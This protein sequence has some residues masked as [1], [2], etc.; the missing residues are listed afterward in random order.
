MP[1]SVFIMPNELTMK[2]SNVAISR[3]DTMRLIHSSMAKIFFALLLLVLPLYG[4]AQSIS[5]QAPTRVGKNQEFS[6]TYT[7]TNS[8]VESFSAPHIPVGLSVVGG[9]SRQEESSTSIINGNV[10]S[11]RSVSYTIY[12]VATSAGT[13][14]I[15][16]ANFTIGGRLVQSRSINLKVDNSSANQSP[17]QSPHSMQQG[18]FPPSGM[19][20]SPSFSTEVSERDLYFTVSP[21]QT[22]VY[23]Q[24]AVLLTYRFY[25][26]KNLGLSV[27]TGQT[28]DFK[29]MVTIDIENASKT[30]DVTQE[31]IGGRPYK[32]GIVKKTLI[33]PQKSGTI[34]I[35][36]ITFQCQIETTDP[37]GS[38]FSTPSV[39]ERKVKDIQINVLPLPERP[40]AFNG[41]VGQLSAKAEIIGGTPRTNDLG[42]YR[43]TISGVGN[44]KLIT[45]QKINFP[46]SFETYEPR[47]TDNTKVDDA[48]CT[49][50]VVFEYRFVPREVGQFTIP[51]TP[52]VY[53]DP[54]DKTYHT[55]TLQSFPLNIKQGERSASDVDEELELMR[56]DINAEPQKEITHLLPK[57]GSPL[58]ILLCL[59]L[60]ALFIW[61]YKWIG[62]NVAKRSNVVGWRRSKSGK[63]ASVRLRKA[64]Q[65]LN[66][67]DDVF[68]AEILNAFKLYIAEHYNVGVGEISK[69]K[70]ADLLAE[71]NVDSSLQDE[72]L[73]ILDECEQVRFSGVISSLTKPE[74][75]QKANDIMNKLV[76]ANTPKKR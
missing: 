1:F 44:L 25:C 23:E 18:I 52:F 50:N 41:A 24:Q 4:Y 2:C 3:K 26:G 76:N 46:E 70:I 21:S 28:P 64:E 40:A 11:S 48:G 27:G 71:D 55:I 9:P 65:L 14:T 29:D 63:K 13:Y 66:E 6:I 39:V 75:L 43:I 62:K 68:C 12:L 10:S 54:T 17:Q 5:V 69:Q 47:I 49:G 57:W 30:P 31:N 35:P 19:P 33:F 20:S 67:K 22:T 32:T 36:G 45:P 53:F 38:F 8:N 42:T 51:Q 37:F 58:Y 15:P 73:T 34:T 72:L 61:V 16:S 7:A 74:M 59:I 60:V 56:S